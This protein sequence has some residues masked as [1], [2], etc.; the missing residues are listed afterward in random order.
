MTRSES[1]TLA[2]SLAHQSAASAGCAVH[3]MVTLSHP[4]T[5]DGTVSLVMAGPGRDGRNVS[6][7]LE[8]LMI[9]SVMEGQGSQ[10]DSQVT[11][12]H[13]ESGQGPDTLRTD[14]MSTSD[15]R[16]TTNI[17]RK[18]TVT[19]Q[20]QRHSLVVYVGLVSFKMMNSINIIIS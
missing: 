19:T 3:E 7:E 12:L 20:N 2:S 17:M 13:T 11:T 9:I 14:T 4:C 15:S 1:E 8:L 5:G 10:E 6:G 16:P 18:S